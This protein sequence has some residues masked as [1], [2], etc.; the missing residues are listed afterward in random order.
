MVRILLLL[1]A[2]LFVP[3]P[4]FAEE[5]IRARPAATR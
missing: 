5:G 2:C 3:A 1:V 4:A